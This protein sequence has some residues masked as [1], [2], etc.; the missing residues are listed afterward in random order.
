MPADIIVFATGFEGNMQ[1]LVEEIFGAEVAE[2][3]G[4]YWGLDEE[5]EVRGLCSGEREFL[6]LFLSTN[7]GRQ[8][9]QRGKMKGEREIG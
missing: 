7:N 1:L 5:G 6:F 3:M 8:I 4:G 9:G 2:E